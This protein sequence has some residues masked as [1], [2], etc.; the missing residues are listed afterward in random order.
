MFLKRRSIYIVLL[1]LCLILPGCGRSAD[2]PSGQPS[3]GLPI[4]SESTDTPVTVDIAPLPAFSP[5]YDARDAYLNGACPVLHRESGVLESEIL[6]AD[7][8]SVRTPWYETS[9]LIYHAGGAVGGQTYTNSR[10]AIE[11][12]LSR[13]N[14]LLEID[15][16]FTSDGHLVCL[17]EWQN[18]QGLT[19]PCTLERFLSLKIYY[20]YTTLTAEDIIGYMRAYPD[21]YL[22]VDTK[23]RSAVDVTAELLR[24]CDYDSDVADRFV[25]QLYEQGM[26]AQILALYPFGDDNFLFTAYKFG[27]YRVTDIMNL[28]LDENIRIVTV[29]YGSWDRATVQKF[30]D[31]GFYV[32][33]HTVNYTSMTD[34]ALARGVYGF[35]TDTLEEHD[36]D[37]SG[38][39]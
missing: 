18:L 14:M 9:R 16:L 30:N 37:G 15:F 38:E 39:N 10:E 8:W 22:I 11:E 34:N 26:K 21:M 31:A 27:A 20:Q 33:E 23:E 7:P 1:L 2:T 36:L 5:A 17:H 4:S 13:G 28:C 6:A 29:P 25:I 3:E 35:Y 19:R 32:F 24:L 12:T